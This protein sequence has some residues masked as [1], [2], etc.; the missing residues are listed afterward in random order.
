MLL[1]WQDL[2]YQATKRSRPTWRSCP[3]T[4]SDPF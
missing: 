2:S 1:S 3:A 4:S